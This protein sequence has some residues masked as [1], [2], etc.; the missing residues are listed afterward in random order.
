MFDEDEEIMN[1][2]I[3]DNYL[4]SQ[5]N[6]EDN[7]EDEEFINITDDMLDPTNPELTYKTEEDDAD[8]DVIPNSVQQKF[9]GIPRSIRSLATFYNS[10]PQDEWDK[11]R[12]EAEVM[13]RE[14]NEAA[15][16]ATVYDGNPKPKSFKE[17]QNIPEF[18]NWWEAM[19]VEFRNI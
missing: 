13:V 1:E 11:I 16:L 8:D 10:N 7:K 9:A 3:G 15:Y 4:P 2:E 14:T 12:G 6:N 18:S 5:L 17:V 19:C